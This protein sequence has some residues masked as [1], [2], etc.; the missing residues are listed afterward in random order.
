MWL[1]KSNKFLLRYV[2]IERC[3]M[4]LIFFMNKP[5]DPRLVWVAT[6]LAVAVLVVLIT[7]V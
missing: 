7:H 1:G 5:A 6:V 2:K 4:W 3:V